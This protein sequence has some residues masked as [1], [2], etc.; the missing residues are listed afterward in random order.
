VPI[1][2]LLLYDVQNKHNQNKIL[3]DKV[4]QVVRQNIQLAQQASSAYET[5]SEKLKKDPSWDWSPR[6]WPLTCSSG[7]TMGKDGTTTRRRRTF[8][9][10]GKHFSKRRS[11]SVNRDNKSRN[12]NK[13]RESEQ[14]LEGKNRKSKKIRYQKIGNKKN[15]KL[16]SESRKSESQT[17]RYKE[18][19][20][21][22]IEN[23]QDKRNKKDDKLKRSQHKRAQFSFQISH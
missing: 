18:K 15:K 12:K 20:Y 11:E 9:H 5:P 6:L 17:K 13:E 3:G 2:D 21:K 1:Q 10:G 23:E 16:K 8:H 7:T 4:M 22:K 19:G 14:K